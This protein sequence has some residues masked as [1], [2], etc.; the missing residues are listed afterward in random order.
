VLAGYAPG[1]RL[2]ERIRRMIGRY[3]LLRWLAEANWLHEYGYDP[4]QSIAA[5][6]HALSGDQGRG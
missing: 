6:R 3:R 2:A 1:P 5:V 4:D